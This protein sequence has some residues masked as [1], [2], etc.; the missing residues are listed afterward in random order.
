M[1]SKGLETIDFTKNNFLTIMTSK[2]MKKIVDGRRV[3]DYS[4][5]KIQIKVN[6]EPKYYEKDLFENLK[7]TQLGNKT[8]NG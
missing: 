1:T 8:K 7:Q 2:D 5:M 4:D 3:E 6:M